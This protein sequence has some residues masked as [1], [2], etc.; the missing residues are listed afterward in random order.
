MDGGGATEVVVCC[1]VGAV[2]D[3]VEGEGG[4]GLTTGS[5]S[6]NASSSLPPGWEMK[7]RGR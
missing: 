7:K 5:K 3:V 2:G 6:G 1:G 4:R